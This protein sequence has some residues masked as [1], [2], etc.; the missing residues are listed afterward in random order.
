MR[1]AAFGVAAR[2]AALAH[3][4][5]PAARDTR[6][7]KRTSRER[8]RRRSSAQVEPLETARAEPGASTPSVVSFIPRRGAAVRRKL[9]NFERLQLGL[10]RCERAWAILSR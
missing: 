7:A 4:V 8:R 6:F 5:T 9:R 3:T 10:A 2:R 1:G